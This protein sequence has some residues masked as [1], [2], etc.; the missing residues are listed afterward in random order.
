MRRFHRKQTPRLI[1]L[2]FPYT[3]LPNSALKLMN[4]PGYMALRSSTSNFEELVWIAD[5]QIQP[6]LPKS[7]QFCSPHVN[8]LQMSRDIFESLDLGVPQGGR[9]HRCSKHPCK[10]QDSPLQPTIT[11]PKMSG[12]LS[13]RNPG[14]LKCPW[15]IKQDTPRLV[16]FF[17]FN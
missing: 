11:R 1:R 3:Y 14:L 17:T 16:T 4:T 10:A 7:R 8:L 5:V 13:S 15:G 2:F 6:W 12:V 9:C